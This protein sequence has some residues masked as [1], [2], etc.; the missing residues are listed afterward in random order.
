MPNSGPHKHADAERD[1]DRQQGNDVGQRIEAIA[2][3][4]ADAALTVARAR[5]R[6]LAG[7]HMDADV[8]GPP[9]QIVHH[10][11]MQDL[12][13]ARTRSD[14]PMMMWVTLFLCA[15]ASTSS[16]MRRAGRRDA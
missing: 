10:R 3:S 4:A 12:E 7:D 1:S 9:H 5:R 14:L 11:P 16:A 2:A 6:F 15:K 8:A 13:P